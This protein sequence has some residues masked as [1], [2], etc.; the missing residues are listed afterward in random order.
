MREPS[1]TF[2]LILAL[3]LIMGLMFGLSAVSGENRERVKMASL[4]KPRE[5]VRVLTSPKLP[6]VGTYENLK[7]L[8][9]ENL[10][11]QSYFG[12]NNRQMMNGTPKSRRSI[13]NLLSNKPAR[14]ISP[15]GLDLSQSQVSKDGDFSTTNVQVQGVDEAD[16]VKTDGSHI[17]QISGQRLIT[18]RAFPPSD[19]KIESE[20]LFETSF[21][22]IELYVDQD[23][24]IVVGDQHSADK[25][26]PGR[27][28]KA[29]IYDKG[30]TKELKKIREVEIDGAYLSSRKIGNALYLVANKDISP[31]LMME[32]PDF[33]NILTPKYKDSV[34]F[35][36]YKEI[37][38]NE[39]SY[40]P[41]ATEAR[42]LTIAGLDLTRP[43]SEVN[44]ATYLGAGQ[45]IY[46]SVNNLYVVTTKVNRDKPVVKSDIY[47]F[48]LDGGNIFFQAEGSV[49]GQMLNQFSMDEYE[50]NLR[51]ATTSQDGGLN[52]N[53]FVLDNR[54]KTIG[55]LENIAPGES[56]YS[57]RFMGERA[58]M[59]T[60]KKVD[61]FFVIDLKVPTN[62][63]ILGY[64]KIPGYSDYLHPY[65]EN[66][67]IGFGKDTVESKSGEFS[68][69][70]GVKIAIFD[71][72]DVSQP[73]EKFKTVIGDRGSDS[74][75]LRDHK[76][77]LFDKE[78]GLMALPI[79]VL[80]VRGKDKI[81]PSGR[82]ALGEFSYQA[83]H[84]YKLDLGKRFKLKGKITH[85][86]DKSINE[87]RIVNRI[88]Y[89]NN[90]IFT[91]SQSMIKA[92]HM[93]NL[94]EIG[95]LKISKD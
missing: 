66:H 55:R 50:G 62:P 73:K 10:N 61:P 36:G 87:S 60:F 86:D 64:L 92:N 25:G 74:Q 46:A 23:Y 54:L 35:S 94:E 16:I 38:Y 57:A 45:N 15:L 51:I 67:I 88:L 26:M 12:L 30:E 95:S 8:L 81:Y 48:A 2:R 33:E 20:I 68:W 17:Y 90:T 43:E 89:I 75:L 4:D 85:L 40:F 83:A 63:T 70:Q 58:Y 32:S 49:P 21:Q 56:I 37:K 22:P 1:F 13:F 76:A 34:S 80:Q 41:G 65:D 19:M 71:V 18:V 39:I 72:S 69:Y 31:Y 7:A 79:R 11:S 82:P 77:L 24:L 78:K 52:N 5:R 14:A 47:R 91:T 93:D 59:V 29:I 42:Y 3:T 53:M 6:K 28:A 27:K 44:V 84:I 9:E